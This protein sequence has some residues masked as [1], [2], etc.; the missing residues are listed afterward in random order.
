M[1]GW[2]NASNGLSIQTNRACPTNAFWDGAL[3]SSAVPGGTTT[4]DYDVEAVVRCV[5]RQA[6]A[7]GGVA[8]RV[9]TAA[10]TGY[11]LTLE[12]DGLYLRKWVANVNP[13]FI[14]RETLTTVVSTDYTIR[15]E[16]RGTSIAA[17]RGGVQTITPQTDS[18]ITAAGRPGVYSLSNGANPTTTVY[19]VDSITATDLSSGTATSDSPLPIRRFRN[20]SLTRR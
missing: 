20:R 14:A 13:T 6:G 16:M 15:L 9:A 19:H 2:T 10:S 4:A 1:T 8:G 5:S 18:S 11:I 3:Y 12:D 17:Y 7:S